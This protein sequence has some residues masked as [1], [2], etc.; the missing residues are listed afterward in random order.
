MV[1]V[2]SVVVAQF[3]KISLWTGIAPIA[4]GGTLT[5]TYPAGREPEEYIQA[6]GA[7][8]S[9]HETQGLYS[10]DAGDFV[11]TFGPSS[12][13]VLYNGG[14]TIPAGSTAVLQIPLQAGGVIG[15]GTNVGD[16]DWL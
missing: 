14:A 13:I 2:S 7:V 1:A 3:D 11:L 16:W 15:G 8:I 10:Q 9:I 5:F 4:P 6:R 12:V